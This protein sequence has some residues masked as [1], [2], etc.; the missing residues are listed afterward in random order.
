MCF[1]LLTLLTDGIIPRLDSN[2]YGATVYMGIDV[3]PGILLCMGI[4]VVP[5]L[6]IIVVYLVLCFV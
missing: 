5:L 6:G 4:S 3:V 2:S 1:M